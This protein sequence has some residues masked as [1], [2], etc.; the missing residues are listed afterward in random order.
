[1]RAVHSCNSW[2]VGLFCSGISVLLILGVLFLLYL[3]FVILISMFLRYYNYELGTSYCSYVRPEQSA[4][5]STFGT[6]V[7]I[8]IYFFL[9]RGNRKAHCYICTTTI[10]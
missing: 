3:F 5:T 8:F 1:M 6:F 4:P 2:L 7:F 9:E 10:Y